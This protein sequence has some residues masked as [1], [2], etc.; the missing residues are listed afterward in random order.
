MRTSRL[1]HAWPRLASRALC[2]VARELPPAPLKWGET[3]SSSAAPPR[4]S[5][6]CEQYDHLC[7]VGSLQRDPEQ[8]ALVVRLQSLREE[9]RAHSRQYHAYT[10]ALDR[11]HMAVRD[12]RQR[13]AAERRRERERLAALPVWRR[14]LMQV[15][16]MVPQDDAESTAPAAPAAPAATA[17][18][19]A[20]AASPSKTPLELR[21]RPKQ[22]VS[23]DTDE[24]PAW[25]ERFEQQHDAP[26][27]GSGER[28]SSETPDHDGMAAPNAAHGLSAQE[29]QHPFWT[30]GIGAAALRQASRAVA[31]P[32]RDDDSPPPPPPPP[33]PPKGL[34]IHGNVGG[35]KTLLMDLFAEAV[36]ADL[37]TDRAAHAGDR[38]GDQGARPLQLRRVHFNAFIIECHRRLHS[39]TMS[40][41]ESAKA[42]AASTGAAST[43]AAST[44]AEASASIHSAA[45]RSAA[46]PSADGPST[47]STAD[48]AE[49]PRWNVITELVRRLVS[50]GDTPSPERGRNL[51]LALDTI[52][53]EIMSHAAMVSEGGREVDVGGSSTLPRELSAPVPGSVVS[54]SVM[55]AASDRTRVVSDPSGNPVSSGVLCFDEVQFMD[56]ADATVVTGVL[57]RLFS[58]GWVLVATCNRTPSEFAESVLHREHPQA[59]F[60]T[61]V[62]ALCE[63]ATLAT[64]EG[65]DYRLRLKPAAEPSFLHPLGERTAAEHERFF[66]ELTA[67]AAAERTEPI[68]HGR[69]L[70]LRACPRG[71]AKLS[72][73]SLCDRPLGAADYIALAQRFH[74]LFLTDVPQLSLRDRDKARRFIT[75]VDQLYNHR[76]RLISTAEVPISEL[77]T[78][79]AGGAPV[80]IDLEGLEFEGEAG[81]IDEL[82]PIGVTAN[83]LPSDGVGGLARTGRVAADSRKQLVH[84]SLF[85]GEDEA[86]A[87]R[88][89]ISRL[90]EM[91]SQQYLSMHAATRG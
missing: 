31:K 5:S 26:A 65:G 32:S 84:D 6:L 78:G 9:L 48:P 40:E 39:H 13:R 81:K 91:Q 2:D 16:G 67:G 25:L 10:L 62:Q 11:W 45:E 60:T 43:G 75:L 23:S 63:T 22:E 70:R 46:D 36:A 41:L 3:A 42:A 20:P 79:S 61:R 73:V 87:F 4:L 44:S 27:A 83:A 8:R 82:N 14:A 72:F 85:T 52:S 12:A 19:A 49:A 17:A 18:P 90:M 55:R 59:R 58:A 54:D 33:P 77:F 29:R 53:A 37:A 7:D 68:A 88:R 35:G 64:R 57:D 71:V 74:T 69:S 50:E 76:V 80:P 1:R 34:F 89:A 86:F 28:A 56:I 15:I 66:Q 51:H 21:I 24:D 30:S 38:V 47:A